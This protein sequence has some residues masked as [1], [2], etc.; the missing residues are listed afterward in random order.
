MTTTFHLSTDDRRARRPTTA[1][2][3]VLSLCSLSL[4]LDWPSTTIA[5]MPIFVAAGAAAAYSYY[6]KRSSNLP[7]EEEEGAHAEAEKGK[8]SCST[9]CDCKASANDDPSSDASGEANKTLTGTHAGA[10]API[11]EKEDD[12]PVPTLLEEW[13]KKYGANRGGPGGRTG[14]SGKKTRSVEGETLSRST[15]VPVPVAESSASGGGTN[16][17]VVVEASVPAETIGVNDKE[18]NKNADAAG[19]ATLL[20]SWNDRYPHLAKKGKQR[21]QRFDG[22]A[23]KMVRNFLTKR[24]SN[25]SPANAKIDNNQKPKGETGITENAESSEEEKE[26]KTDLCE[27]EQNENAILE[28]GREGE[29]DSSTEGAPFGADALYKEVA[30]AVFGG[31][32]STC[33]R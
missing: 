26:Q 17:N 21:R 11:P 33:N 10:E 24:N 6:K 5:T 20:E 7:E 4:S 19:N 15:S 12:R 32:L 2:S 22:P 29:K 1:H 28:P 27:L 9:S 3:T 23:G 25:V 31:E 16:D 8:C 18:T 14:T 13:N 30:S